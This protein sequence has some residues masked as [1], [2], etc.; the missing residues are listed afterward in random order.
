[1]TKPR[2]VELVISSC[3]YCPNL[4]Y[5]QY[6]QYNYCGE[7]DTNHKIEDLNSFPSFC[8]LKEYQNEEF[9]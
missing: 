8:P 2:V 6:Q 5:E 7:F 3:R 9:F 4:F 1:M